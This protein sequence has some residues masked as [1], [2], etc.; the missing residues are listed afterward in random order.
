MSYGREWL[1]TTGSEDSHGRALWA[2]GVV[3]DRGHN[4]GQV[5]L[6]VKLFH[7]ALPALEGF[8]DSRA[9]AFPILGI[10]AYLHSHDD[11]H[12]VRDLLK[13]LGD[14]LQARFRQYA[15]KDWQW[16]ESMLAY[17][18]ARLAQALMACG[19]VTNDDDMVKTG[20][21]VGN[22]GWFPKSGSKAQYD[23]QPVEAAAMIGACME[24]HECTQDEKW[25]QLAST[26]FN[27]YLGKNDRQ[28]K[29]YDHASG[30]CRD[31]LTP[32]G[33]NENQGAESM[34][35]Y[36][37]SLLAIYN[38]RGLTVNH[39]D[40]KKSALEAEAVKIPEVQLRSADVP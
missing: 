13:S 4:S 1:E 25:V 17:D 38:L 11:D 19:R 26:C 39:Q 21:E 7:D 30:G 33:V 10:Q 15:S 2:L 16:H 31:G 34:L 22:K 32:D 20:I 40:A 23:Q 5:A 14:R 8:S 27:W 18:N 12:Q 6:A 37:S 35:S 28:A 9:I 3:A 29:L 24:A 36:L